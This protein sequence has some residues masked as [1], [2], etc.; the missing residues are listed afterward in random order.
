VIPKKPCSN[1]SASAIRTGIHRSPVPP[2]HTLLV[3]HRTMITQ[4]FTLDHEDQ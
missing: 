4:T 1:N 2:H 3:D